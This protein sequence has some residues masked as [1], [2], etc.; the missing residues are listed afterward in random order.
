M[1]A[2]GWAVALRSQV[3]VAV[4]PVA[5]VL[6]RSP[7]SSGSVV[8]LSAQSKKREARSLRYGLR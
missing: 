4:V 6:S 5:H 7:P 8:E 1:R 3:P 2:D